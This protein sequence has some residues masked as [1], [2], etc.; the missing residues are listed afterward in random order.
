MDEGLTEQL[1][2][3]LDEGFERLV[4]SRQ[5]RLFAFALTLTQDGGEAEE[6]AQEAFVRAYRALEKYPAGRI[7]ELR[8]DGWLHRIVLNLVRNR[9]RSPRPAVLPLEDL[10]P[11][12]RAGPA[13]LFERSD[14]L[15]RLGALVAELPLSQREAVV[16]R[17]VQG[18]RYAEVAELLE[19]P[20]GTVKS[21][22]HRGLEA[23]RRRLA[24]EVTA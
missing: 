15:R 12:L 20:L 10:V 17:C 6:I 8:L 22:V 3:D 14:G 18:F 16:L 21:N 4:R 11:D 1:A 7:R 23:L 24:S 2:A 13:E 5:N 19:Q 9:R